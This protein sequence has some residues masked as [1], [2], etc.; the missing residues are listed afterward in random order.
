MGLDAV[1]LKKGHRD[2]VAIITGRV[3]TE[4]VML[5]VFPD[6]KKAPV[7][8]CLSGLPPRLRHMLRLVC[9]DRDEGF[10]HAANEVVGKGVKSGMDRFQVAK[11]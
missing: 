4:T 5:G 7:T 8:A 11:R 9:T 10:V 6:R 2:F 3:E 1:A